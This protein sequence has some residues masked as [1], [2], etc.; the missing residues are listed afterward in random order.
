[1]H[2]GDGESGKK[3]HS[4]DSDRYPFYHHASAA[5]ERVTQPPSP[6]R[7]DC[8]FPGLG[9]WLVQPGGPIPDS[10]PSEQKWSGQGQNTGALRTLDAKSRGFDN[11]GLTKTNQ[12]RRPGPPPLSGPVSQASSAHKPELVEGLG[13]AG[14][15][16]A[17]ML[18]GKCSQEDFKPGN[19]EEE[20]TSSP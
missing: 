4:W 7:A 2:G 12:Q 15:S 17:G 10:V 18:P 6:K 1:M 16:P 9:L 20:G 13:P 5:Q 3:G 8:G 14:Q 11:R 19:T